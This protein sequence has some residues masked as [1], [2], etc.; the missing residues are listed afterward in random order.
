VHQPLFLFNDFIASALFSSFKPKSDSVPQKRFTHF[1]GGLHLVDQGFKSAHF[2]FLGQLQVFHLL[3]RLMRH[4]SLFNQIVWQ[5]L[6]LVSFLS[7][8]HGNAVYF[9]VKSRV[10]LLFHALHGMLIANQLA[11]LSNTLNLKNQR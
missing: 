11:V 8:H 2:L 5:R 9:G 10:A 3:S 4:L 7:Q 1:L 6:V